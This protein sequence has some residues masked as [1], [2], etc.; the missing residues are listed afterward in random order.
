VTEMMAA[1]LA[2]EIKNPVA[3]AMAYAS[4]IR[5]TGDSPEI[6]E[7]CNLIQQSLLDISDLVQDLLFAAHLRSEPCIINVSEMLAEMLNEYRV[8][9]PGISFAI[10]ADPSFTCYANEQHVRLIF[11]NLLKNAA[12][13]AEM[14]GE[15]YVTVY[16]TKVCEYL[17]VSIHNSGSFDVQKKPHGSGMGLGICDW[18]IKQLSGELKIGKNATEDGYVAIVSLPCNF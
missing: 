13:A 4:L 3:L 7:Y 5:Q 12:E 8:A 11:S 16:T 14:T 6:N 17:Q 9:M 1:A 2:H 15:G 18:L 10:N